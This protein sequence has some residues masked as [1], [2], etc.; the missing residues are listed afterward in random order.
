MKRRS[1]DDR[2]LNR[3]NGARVGRGANWLGAL[4]QAARRQGPRQMTVSRFG[5]AFGKKKGPERC[6]GP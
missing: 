6:S 3:M 4:D 5:N 2:G 1:H